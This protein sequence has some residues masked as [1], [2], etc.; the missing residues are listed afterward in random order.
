[1]AAVINTN[2]QSL[3]A[4][5]NMGKSSNI[6]STALQR[7]SS[8]LRINSAKDDA[9]GLA[10]SERMTS[11]I[12]GLNQAARN[13]NDGIS[14]A[15][16][17]ES[18]MSSITDTLQRIRELAVQSSNAT[19]SA[20]DRQALQGEVNQLVAELDRQAVSAEFN[21]Q[22]IFDGSF[23]AASFQ[24]GANA[25]ETITTTTA[26]FRTTQYGVNRVVGQASAAAAG[27]GAITAGQ[28]AA[29]TGNR[30]NGETLTINGSLGSA[31]ITVVDSSAQTVA[32]QVNDVSATTGVKAT[33]STDIT[34]MTFSAAGSYAFTLKSDNATAVN[35][36]FSLTAASGATALAS[37]VSAIND[38]SAKTGVSASV[39]TAGSGLNLSNATGNTIYIANSAAGNT[40]AGTITAGT[41]IVAAATG[42]ANAI[43]ITG[44]VTLLSEKTFSATGTTLETLALAAESSALNA[45]NTLDITNFANAQL[46]IN[47]VDGAMGSVNTQRAKFG[48][49]QSRFETAIANL[50]VSS[51][52]LSASRS[53][54]LDTD[55][56]QETAMLTRGQILQQA[57]MAMLAQANALPNSVL[58]LL[59]G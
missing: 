31:A 2:V 4:Q 28:I 37:A 21:G 36:S 42:A 56:A 50:N 15:Q 43:A 48:A 7:L 11:Q 1:M 8:G 54:I 46:A 29:G 59:R 25:K 9:A 30:I 45:V 17:A 13:A 41:G 40:N 26:N 34:D 32:Q 10:I 35:V 20:S 33:A 47:I 49:M 58:T 24:I 16:A 3:N 18:S 6:L 14:L 51:E 23:G 55:Y 57:G 12:R 5:R 22:K 27:A 19:N 44:Q 53:R 52:N 39:N 38:Q